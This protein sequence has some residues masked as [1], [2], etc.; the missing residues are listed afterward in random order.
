MSLDCVIYGAFYSILFRGPFFFPD[1]VYN[2]VC[3]RLVG[4][5]KLLP[6]LKTVIIIVRSDVHGI[7]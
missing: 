3:L 7:A 2:M 1:T 4:L 6:Y 5:Y